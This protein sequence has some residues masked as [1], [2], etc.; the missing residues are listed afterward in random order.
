LIFSGA[1]NWTTFCFALGDASI[2]AMLRRLGTQSLCH[3]AALL[4]YILSQ[5][6][7]GPQQSPCNVASDSLASA[8]WWRSAGQPPPACSS[9]L[10]AS[11]DQLAYIQRMADRGVSQAVAVFA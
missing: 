2:A 7:C 5:G 4:A 8:Q 1:G 6:H 3:G 11:R 10:E 9:T